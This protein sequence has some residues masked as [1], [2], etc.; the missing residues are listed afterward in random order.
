MTP[1]QREAV[2]A[3][4][5]SGRSQRRVGREVG[6]HHSTVGSLWR[7]F[8]AEE[9]RPRPA[10]V[11]EMRELAED[12]P[13][14]HLGVRVVLSLRG[15]YWEAGRLHPPALSLFNPHALA[16]GIGGELLR[17]LTGEPANR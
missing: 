1:E 13:G 7:A 15:R 12:Y 11:G 14:E 4:W 16:S 17:D 2:W 3:A 10:T 9:C 6:L 5:R 8:E